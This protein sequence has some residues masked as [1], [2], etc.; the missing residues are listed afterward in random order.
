[1]LDNVD[2]VLG[3]YTP[4]FDINMIRDRLNRTVLLAAVLATA[5]FALVICQLFELRSGVI[6]SKLLASSAFLAVAITAGAL[7]TRYGQAVLIGLATR[8]G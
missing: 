8:L 3:F 4:W 7:H 1:M 5:C 2:R 6:A